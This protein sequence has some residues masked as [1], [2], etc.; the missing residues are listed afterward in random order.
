MK[1]DLKYSFLKA[2]DKIE[3]YCAYQER[4]HDEVNKK[5]M[6]WGVD[7][8]DRDALMANL[9]ENNFLNEERYAFAYVS[10][11]INIKKWG[12]R[13]VQFGLKAK[14]IPDY[15]ISKALLDVDEDTYLNNLMSIAE[16]K[17]S[18][19][20]GNTYQK[21]A[22][23]SAYLYQRGYEGELVSGVLKNIIEKEESI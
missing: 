2:K 21:K 18:E 13:K 11:K 14:K 8:E 1:K 3:A 4:C 5:L 22:K 10:G 15:L 20:N 17:W 16:K 19:K 7:Q 12:K 9:I 23:V 6:S